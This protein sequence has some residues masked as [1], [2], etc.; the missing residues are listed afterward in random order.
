MKE[1][2]NSNKKDDILSFHN[3]SIDDKLLDRPKYEATFM[4]KPGFCLNCLNAIFPCFKKV[5]TKTIRL[6]YFRNSSLN[7]TYWSNKEENHKYNA[8]FFFPVVLFNQFRQFSNFFY[9][10]LS[11]SQFIPQFKVGFLFTYIS[12]LSTLPS[13]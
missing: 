4:K 8:L 9:L 13:S 12:P 10:L 7:V 5:D 3:D 2:N 6:V 11:I 1:N